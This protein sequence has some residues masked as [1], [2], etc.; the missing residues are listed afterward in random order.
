MSASAQQL[1]VLSTTIERRFYPRI[2][3]HAPIFLALGE[4]KECLLINV[5]E[6]GLLVS[7]PGEIR[8][9]FVARISIALN[10][11]P[12]PVWVNARVVWTSEGKKLAGIQLLDLSDHDREQIR[13]WGEQESR[14][15]W[16][17]EAKHHLA[18]GAP[19]LTSSETTR[20]MSL[21]AEQEAFTGLPEVA[22]DAAPRIA[23]RRTASAA[24]GIATWGVLIATVS[25][26]ATFV[27]RN[28]APGNF[29]G[30][31]AEKS[32]E[33]S[34]AGPR[35]PDVQGNAQN[36]NTPSRDTESQAAS[37]A[38]GVGAA[39]SERGLPAA[40]A[41]QNSLQTGEVRSD[42]VSKGSAFGAAQNHGDGSRMNST[43]LSEPAVEAEPTPETS[44]SI[45]DDRDDAQND[46]SL[47]D[48]IPAVADA[49]PKTSSVAANSSASDDARPGTLP[50]VVD[51]PTAREATRNPMSANN[52]A[53]GGSATIGSRP[54]V[55]STPP[56]YVRKPDGGVIQ[57]DTPE[58]QVLDIH[59]PRG[60]QAPFFDLPGERVLESPTVTMHVQ[61]SVHIPITH[62]G[63]ASHRN[64]RVIVGGLVSRVD[65]QAGPVQGSVGDSVLVKAIVDKDGRVESVRPVHGSSNLVMAVARAVREWR[66]QPTLIDNK[67]VETECYV[68]AQFHAPA[69]RAARQ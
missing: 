2:A 9:N 38:P 43:S 59:L 52:V 67:P 21:L 49:T 34:A 13:K 50:G 27:L 40:S 62:V 30:R 58:R 65:P 32:Y 60:Y 44:D 10:G 42:D 51:P 11:L 39:K 3:P 41:L 57:M 5:G 16:Q 33:D 66:Y 64:K 47:P 1:E 48:E 19:F 25:L 4:S 26:G 22:P 24:A 28:G 12:R 35:V 37:P 14:L 54:S 8:R 6:N 46:S 69:R 53:A 45:A 7:T 20:A 29:F 55:P 36:S 18:A 17:P 61:R 15:S 63:W 56:A 23:R 31:S 68:V